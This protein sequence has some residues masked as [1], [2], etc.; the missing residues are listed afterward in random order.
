MNG[1]SLT[2][3]RRGVNEAGYN[4]IRYYTVE[5]KT[6]TRRGEARRLCAFYAYDASE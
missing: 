3:S 2:L 1:I 5:K 4:R 6:Q